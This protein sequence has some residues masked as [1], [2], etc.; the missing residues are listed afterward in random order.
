LAYAR[1]ALQAARGN[2]TATGEPKPPT[3][4]EKQ[5]AAY[6]AALNRER[7]T[8]VDAAQGL[9]SSP[10]PDS[11]AGGAPIRDVPDLLKRQLREGGDIAEKILAFLDKH[12]G[13]DGLKMMSAEERQRLAY[14]LVKLLLEHLASKHGSSNDG[15]RSETQEGQG[16]FSLAM[17][18]SPP[19]KPPQFYLMS[20]T[21]RREVVAELCRNGHLLY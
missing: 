8:P 17:I 19:G 6:R 13:V 3:K 20:E 4:A 9:P 7:F 1:A 15:I 10:P 14:R 12:G 11:I 21:R 5:A 16:Q 2:F 18:Q